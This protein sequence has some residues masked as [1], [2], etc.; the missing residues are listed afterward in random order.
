M[1]RYLRNFGLGTLFAIALVNL[2]FMVLAKAPLRTTI[3]P[4]SV[5]GGILFIHAPLTYWALRYG[6][7]HGK[8]MRIFVLV[9]VELL[10][11][12][13]VVGVRY[14]VVLGILGRHDGFAVSTILVVFY[15][16]YAAYALLIR[17]NLRGHLDQ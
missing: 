1:L 15:S 14:T 8:D 3:V 9:M 5:I 13:S 16:L 11:V 12:I 6:F 2:L 17:K 4:S 7:S 10:I